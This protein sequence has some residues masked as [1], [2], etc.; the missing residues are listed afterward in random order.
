MLPLYN[1]NNH[2]YVY[3]CKT[4]STSFIKEYLLHTYYKSPYSHLIITN[5]W[6]G[7]YVDAANEEFVY[8]NNINV[9]INCTA[10]VAFYFDSHITQHRV[11]V[12]DDLKDKSFNSMS[13]YLPNIVD[14]IHCHITQGDRVYVHCRSGK[15]RSA[16]I[17]ACYLM[18]HEHKTKDEAIAY[19]KG[20]RNA[21]FNPN[22]N[23]EKCINEYEL[24]FI[25]TVV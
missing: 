12:D 1:N 4:F 19:I 17:V 14:I 5:L 20:I 16:C 6:L 18:A 23:F 10:D 3:K 2:K 9:I 21:C 7:S 22:I 8:K 11:P 13:Y 24:N 25:T 15:Q